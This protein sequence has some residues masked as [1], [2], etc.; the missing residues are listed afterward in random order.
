MNKIRRAE[1]QKIYD[2]LSDTLES[3]EILKEEEEAYLDSIP[4]NMQGSERYEK[5][6][7]AVSSLEGSISSIEEACS[8]IEEAMQ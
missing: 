8:S 2:T 3:L 4:E 6:E 5:A 7:E 1:L